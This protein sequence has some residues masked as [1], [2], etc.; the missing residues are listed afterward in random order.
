MS[1]VLKIWCLQ[2]ILK[3]RNAREKGAATEA[4]IFVFGFSKKMG[5]VQVMGNEIFYWAGLTRSNLTLFNWQTT[6]LVKKHIDL[7]NKKL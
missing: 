3:L 7:P 2:N 4:K 5:S 1:E 6:S